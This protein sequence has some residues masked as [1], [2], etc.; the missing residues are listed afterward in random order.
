MRA[1]LA[2][3]LALM[4]PV[5]AAACV[6]AESEPRVARAHDAA[7]LVVFFGPQS[8]LVYDGSTD[9]DI[10]YRVVDPRVSLK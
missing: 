3:A 9:L 2:I 4:I 7:P 5:L 8:T 1:L 6:Q 10:L